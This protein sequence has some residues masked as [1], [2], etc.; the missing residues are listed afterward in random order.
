[1]LMIIACM[2]ETRMGDHT[3]LAVPADQWIRPR[4]GCIASAHRFTLCFLSAHAHC[5]V[6]KT[7]LQRAVI[8]ILVEVIRACA[9]CPHDKI[10]RVVLAASWICCRR[11]RDH[12]R[13]CVGSRGKAAI[14]I[15]GVSPSCL[16]FL[17]SNSSSL[18]R[19]V[20]AC[21]TVPTRCNGWVG[22]LGPR[23]TRC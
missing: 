23:L 19:P 16:S 11:M 3:A 4:R 15:M 22:G 1:M 13:S 20:A 8:P 10:W 18:P 7:H 6:N 14:E 9:C 2:C 12:R 5:C 17:L 21:T